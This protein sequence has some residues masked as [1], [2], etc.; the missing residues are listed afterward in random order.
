M[1]RKRHCLVGNPLS[2]RCRPGFERVFPDERHGNDN[3]WQG[4]RCRFVVARSYGVIIKVA[5]LYNEGIQE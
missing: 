3:A 5:N 4:I 2:F 1:T